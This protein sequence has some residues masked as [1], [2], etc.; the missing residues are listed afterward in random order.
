MAKD[1]IIKQLKGRRV[2]FS[3]QLKG[4]QSI[5]A[6]KTWQ[7]ECAAAGHIASSGR[8]QR[9]VHATAH[10]AFIMLHSLRLQLTE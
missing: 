7:Q 2:C 3:L 9:E 6:R 5:V 1:M 10:L 4:I 8:K